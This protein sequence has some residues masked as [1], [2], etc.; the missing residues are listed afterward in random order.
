MVLANNKEKMGK[1]K[2]SEK[3]QEAA[4]EDRGN[5]SH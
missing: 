1:P 4:R 5:L 2:P 3:M